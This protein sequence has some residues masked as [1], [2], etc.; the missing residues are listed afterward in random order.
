MNQI[1]PNP[2]SQYQWNGVNPNLMNPNLMHQIQ[3][4][5]PIDL[6]TVTQQPPRKL[7]KILQK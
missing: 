1:Q 6:F 5:N 4:N 2:T 3:I 7:L